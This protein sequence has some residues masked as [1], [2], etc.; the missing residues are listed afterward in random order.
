M[1][2]VE[3][4][5]FTLDRVE[6][7]TDDEGNTV[8]LRGHA[9][10]FNMDSHPIAGLFIERVAPGAF[11]RAITEEQD[12]RALVN[13]DPNIVLGRTKAGTLRLSEDSRGLAVDIDLPDTQAARDIAESVGRGDVD[14]MSFG[15]L[16]RSER[17]DE[18][19]GE[20]LAVRTLLD[21]DLFDVSA[22]TYPAYPQTDIGMR[23]VGDTTE[24]E[25]VYAEWRD[26][27]AA[28]EL[29]EQQ[30]RDNALRQGLAELK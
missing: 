6:L 28:E 7:R 8:G 9:A 10:V 21:V 26:S 23:S 5:T 24:A 27:L 15:F 14:G 29:S 2:K 25:R 18:D 16:V 22:V 12:V 17:W 1:S 20:G 3:T 30:M 13:H 19:G 11:K 4:R